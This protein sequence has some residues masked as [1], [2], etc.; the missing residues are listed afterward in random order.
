MSHTVTSFVVP[1]APTHFSTLSNK[2]YDIRRKGIEHKFCVSI[3]YTSLV[4]NISHSK[5]NLGR[6]C[7]K[8]KKVLVW[9]IRYCCR[10]SM[11]LEFS[12]HIFEKVSNTKFHQNPSSGSRVIPCGR[13][14]TDGR[15]N[16]T[17]LMVAFRYFA[18]A[19]KNAKIWKSNDKQKAKFMI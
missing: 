12:R 8:C 15:T 13:R 18:N 14:Q 7:Q 9:S 5:K 6:Y 16:M 19:P 1:L 11:K 2:R 10:I 17:K 3:F 4:Y